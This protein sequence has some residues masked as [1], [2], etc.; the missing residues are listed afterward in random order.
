MNDL[1]AVAAVAANTLSG[2]VA[3]VTGGSRGIGAATVRRLAQDG[4]DVAFSY[5]DSERKAK[6]LT[7]EIR[8][9]GVRVEALRADASSPG[10]MARLVNDTVTRFG[11]LDILVHNAAVILAGPL[12]AA[13]RDEQAISR[14]F[15]VNLHG[16]VAATR[17]AAPHLPAGGRIILISS[18]GSTRNSGFPIGDYTAT[19]AA[20]EAYGRAWAH[21]F[22]PRGI[23]VNSLQ[24]AGIDTDMLVNRDAA[25][26]MLSTVPMRR[27]GRPED[28]ADAV[29]YLASPAAGYV[30]GA[31]LR[32][33]GGW[34]A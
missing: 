21:E 27:F 1:N 33:D 12:T 34:A 14:Q 8:A 10:E 7:E 6:E 31:T 3:L 23:T 15:Q 26:A 30:T 32:V 5:L 24:P 17:A 28:V 9:M 11:R 18:A 4:A 2:R 22:G 25:A 20:L 13:D 19:K 16:V 29:A